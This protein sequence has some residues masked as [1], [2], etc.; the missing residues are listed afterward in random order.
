MEKVVLLKTQLAEA[1]TFA[2]S[3]R[4]GHKRLAVILLDNFIEIQLSA[5]MQKNFL[6]DEGLFSPKKYTLERKTKVLNHYDELLKVCVKEQIITS[7]ELRLLSYCHEIRNNLYHKGEEEKVLTQAAI[8]IL[9]HIIIKYQPHW[10]SAKNFTAWTNNFEDPYNPKTK[11]VRLLLSAGIV[12][13]IGKVSWIHPSSALI[14]EQKVHQD[15][16]QTI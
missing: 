6:W 4:F 10:K 5:L 3:K 14:K 16:C 13:K 11:A 2:R 9:Y 12:M 7:D 15:C 8:T 1:A